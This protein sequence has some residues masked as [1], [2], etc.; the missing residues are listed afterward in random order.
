MRKLTVLW[1]L[2]PQFGLSV[3]PSTSS[4]YWPAETIVKLPHSVVPIMARTTVPAG[5]GWPFSVAFPKKRCGGKAC[6]AAVPAAVTAT[7]KA[8]AVA[9]V[10]SIGVSSGV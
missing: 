6:A 9:S 1:P 10:R 2:R 3:T 8:A 7:S 5:A 4:W